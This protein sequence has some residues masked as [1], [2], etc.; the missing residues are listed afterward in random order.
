MSELIDQHCTLLEQ[1]KRD[2]EYCQRKD[3]ILDDFHTELVRLQSSDIGIFRREIDKITTLL[4]DNILYLNESIIT[5]F[6]DYL[7][8]LLKQ[9]RESTHF[10]E[11]NTFQ[12]LSIIFTNFYYCDK[13]MNK[14]LI[15]EFNESLNAIARI[16]KNLFTDSNIDVITRILKSYTD[17]ESSHKTSFIEESNFENAIMKCLRTHYILEVF[18]QFKSSVESEERTSTENFVFDGLFYYVSIMNRKHLEEEALTLRKHFLRSISNLLDAYLA[19]PEHWAESAMKILTELTTLFLYS[20]QMTEPNDL[21]IDI[22]IH[23]IGT[24]IQILFLPSRSMKLTINCI[25]YVYMGTFSD[26]ALDYLKSQNL[27]S[28]MLKLINMYKDETEIQFNSYRTLATIMTEEDIKRLDD[29]G[30][31][32]KVFLDQLGIAKDIPGWEI[33]LKNLLTSLKSK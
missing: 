7:T 18:S 31:I 23:I 11:S 17:I 2:G 33:R 30:V 26:K 12:N 4:C 19:S 6:I 13:L 9:W 14:L 3:E 10:T 8:Q 27:T 5:F 20:V 24:C 32:A 16:G 25:Q 29:P 21:D 1:W 22:Q 15:D 28:T